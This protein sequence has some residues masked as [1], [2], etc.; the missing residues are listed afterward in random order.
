M[1]IILFIVNTVWYMS[2]HCV[3][4]EPADTSRVNNALIDVLPLNKKPQLSHFTWIIIIA[5]HGQRK[6]EC[7]HMVPTLLLYSWMLLY[8]QEKPSFLFLNGQKILLENQT[9][10]LFFILKPQNC[11]VSDRLLCK[12]LNLII[13][14]EIKI[15]GK[16]H[17]CSLIPFIR[18]K[19]GLYCDRTL[20]STWV[21]MPEPWLILF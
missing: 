13:F 2:W 8:E 6:L 7:T 11:P 21:I 10:W 3:L 9:F 12:L 15:G 5:L 17:C 18:N 19:H 14:L 20:F 4:N 16:T 1:F